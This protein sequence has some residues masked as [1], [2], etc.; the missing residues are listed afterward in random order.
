MVDYEEYLQTTEWRVRANDAKQRA[1]WQCALCCSTK[2][3]E[4]HHRTYERLGR[5]RSDD[6]IVLCW[7]CHRRHHGTLQSSL[8]KHQ[9]YLEM[10]PFN[11]TFPRGGDL[12]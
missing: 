4:V 8:R 10:M 2:A 11:F 7:R 6:L 12:N 1:K 5:E 3:L 9:R